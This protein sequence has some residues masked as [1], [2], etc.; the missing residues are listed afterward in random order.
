MTIFYE[1]DLA[2]KFWKKYINSDLLKR[3]KLVKPIV[4]RVYDLSTILQYLDNEMK[5]SLKDETIALF[6]ISYFD[7]LIEVVQYLCNKE[8]KN[9]RRKNKRKKKI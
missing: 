2:F 7:D 1:K 5:K 3:E 8:V 4:K 6:L 9:G